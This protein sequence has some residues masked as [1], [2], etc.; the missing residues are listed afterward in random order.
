MIKFDVGSIVSDVQKLYIKDQKS[1]DMIMTGN[2]AKQSYTENDGLIIPK[3]HP[4]LELTSIPVVPFNKFYQFAGNE[5]TGKS[6][7]VGE[8]IA[9]AQKQNWMVILWDAEDKFDAGRLKRQFGGDPDS[10]MLVKTNE[11][12]KGG[13]K[14]R[15]LVHSAKKRYPTANILICWD[16]VGGSQ[17]R[18]HAERELDNEKH[19]QPGQDAK[20]NGN[21]IKMLVSLFNAYPNSISVLLANQVYSKIG[22]M[23]H[24]DKESGGKKVA[25]LS[26]VI[27][28]LKRIKVLLKQVQGK[29]V[30][31]GII[32]R[33]TM[34]K[35][36]MSQGETSVHQL[37]FEI[38]AKGSRVLGSEEEIEE[39][40]D[41]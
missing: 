18:T 4:L 11:I 28:I 1:Q 38:T 8:L 34:Q 5:D 32:T 33:A 37:D 21:V 15:K 40:A 12:L 36:H 26:S 14:V 19:A 20:E 6:T 9:A 25:Y 22:F 41:E 2:A 27:V 17:S 7:M 23:Q 30:K 35:Q 39:E 13:E 3:G 31:Y 29:K 10:L 16:S 24:G